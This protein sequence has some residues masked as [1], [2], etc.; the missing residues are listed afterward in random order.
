MIIG[1]KHNSVVFFKRAQ[2]G[3]NRAVSWTGDAMAGNSFATY[4]F[5]LVTLRT[6]RFR[7]KF[8]LT[9]LEL[10]LP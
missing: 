2:N 4:W 8:R 10:M 1:Q 5:K 6:L 9:S 3:K 7:W